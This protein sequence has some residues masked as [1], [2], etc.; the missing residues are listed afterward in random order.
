MGFSGLYGDYVPDLMGRKGVKVSENDGQ[1]LRRVQ[2]GVLAMAKLLRMYGLGNNLRMEATGRCGRR[3]SLGYRRENGHGPSQHHIG[4]GRS[5]ICSLSRGGRT[6]VGS[7]SIYV[8]SAIHRFRHDESGIPWDRPVH[9]ESVLSADQRRGEVNGK[10][11]RELRKAVYGKRYIRQ[12]EFLN[13]AMAYDMT[14]VKLQEKA[15]GIDLETFLPIKVKTIV[16]AT[17]IC[18]GPRAKYQELKKNAGTRR[19]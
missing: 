17:V 8:Q 1:T 13:P 11:A 2:D 19:A 16:D 10:R 7:T 14:N 18:I 3:D 15:V 9:R 6:L 4:A 12:T 5:Q